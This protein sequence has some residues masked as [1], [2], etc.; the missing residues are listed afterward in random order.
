MSRT[1]FNIF[2]DSIM[3]LCSSKPFKKS[4][5]EAKLCGGS[6]EYLARSLSE[7][8]LLPVESFFL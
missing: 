5:S 7:I 1:L 2:N 6:I 8:E 3:S 4:D